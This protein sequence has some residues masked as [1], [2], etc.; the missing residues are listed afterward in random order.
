MRSITCSIA[1]MLGLILSSGCASSNPGSPG[2][3]LPV[4]GDPL[5][6]VRYDYNPSRMVKLVNSLRTMGKPKALQLLREY[7]ADPDDWRRNLDTQLICRCL[8]VHPRGWY[9]AYMVSGI[10]IRVKFEEEQHFRQFPIAFSD[11]VPFLLVSS[12][13]AFGSGPRAE[14]EVLKQCESYDMISTDLAV[15]EEKRLREAADR[16]IASE[17][18]QRLYA[19]RESLDSATVFIQG[20]VELCLSDR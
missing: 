2:G 16:L 15:P 13:G 4:S 5:R 1:V 14:E 8:F 3:L 18:F 19:D 9:P 11:G 20:Q 10:P 17:D 7:A 12:A 6:F